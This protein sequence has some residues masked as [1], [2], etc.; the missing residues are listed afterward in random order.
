[1][2]KGPGFRGE[3]RGLIPAE[4]QLKS[5]P[6]FLN[7]QYRVESVETLKGSGFGGETQGSI[8]AET[9]LKSPTCQ[10]CLTGTNITFA[11]V[12]HWEL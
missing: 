11:I 10:A 7:D 2:A 8:P 1:M 3:T 4:T 5:P 12:M 9:R 6:Y